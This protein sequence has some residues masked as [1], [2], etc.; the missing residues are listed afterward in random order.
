M[1]MINA[2]KITTL[3]EAIERADIILVVCRLAIGVTKKQ[4]IPREEARRLALIA[5]KLDDEGER[6]YGLH[7]AG[8][9]LDRAPGKDSPVDMINPLTLTF[10]PKD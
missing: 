1:N 4:P 7:G 10:H 2:P 8:W 5:G 9:T 6:Y 3:A